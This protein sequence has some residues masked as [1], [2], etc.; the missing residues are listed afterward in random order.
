[1]AI[2]VLLYGMLGFD[3]IICIIIVGVLAC[4]G[5]VVF[6]GSNQCMNDYFVLV[7]V[8]PHDSF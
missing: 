4:I 7:V 3:E 1:M 2:V 8:F 6:I 5:A